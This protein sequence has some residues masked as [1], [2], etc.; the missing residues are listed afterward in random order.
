MKYFIDMQLTYTQRKNQ[1]QKTGF[2]PHISN[3]EFSP[4]LRDKI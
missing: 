4:I 1:P 3:T 2:S